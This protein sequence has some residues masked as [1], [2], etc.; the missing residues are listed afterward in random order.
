MAMCVRVRITHS[1]VE[2]ALLF[3]MTPACEGPGWCWIRRFLAY[4]TWR[5]YHKHLPLRDPEQPVETR[6]NN[7]EEPAIGSITFRIVTGNRLV[8]NVRAVMWTFTF[9]HTITK[10]HKPESVLSAS[11]GSICAPSRVPDL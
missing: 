1:S 2:A 4:R 10:H 7:I 11:F 8:H 5:H 9:C 3:F 6:S